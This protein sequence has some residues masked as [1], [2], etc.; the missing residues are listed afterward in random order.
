M[1]QPP[2]ISERPLAVVLGATGCIGGGAAL[3]FLRVGWDVFAPVRNLSRAAHL[4]AAGATVVLV[5][6]GDDDSAG[7]LLEALRPHLSRVRAVLSSLG[8]YTKCAP[9]HASAPGA[10]I[11]LLASNVAPHVNGWRALCGALLGARV[12]ATYFFVT[13]KS[14]ETGRK[15]ALSISDAAVFGV[16]AVARA[17]AAAGASALRVVEVRLMFSVQ[18]VGAREFARLFVDI[19]SGRGPRAHSDVIRLDSKASW[20]DAIGADSAA[21]MPAASLASLA[22]RPFASLYGGEPADALAIAAYARAAGAVTEA[23]F[24]VLPVRALAARPDVRR[25]PLAWHAG[26][27]SAAA[28][29]KL[30]QRGFVSL[31]DGATTLLTLAAPFTLEDDALPVVTTTNRAVETGAS[32]LPSQTAPAAAMVT[33]LSAAVALRV[34]ARTALLDAIALM[35]ATPITDKTPGWALLMSIEHKRAVHETVL[36]LVRDLEV[37]DLAG[38]PRGWRRAL[39]RARGTDAAAAAAAPTNALT[40]IVLRAPLRGFALP[41]T[42]DVAAPR[43]VDDADVA[44]RLASRADALRACARAGSADRLVPPFDVSIYKVSNAEFLPFVVSGGYSDSRW[45]GGVAP[46]A[47][48]APRYWGRADGHWTL[49]ETWE[50]TP[51]PWDWPVEVDFSEA[52]AFLAWLT[53]RDGGGRVLHR[54]PT[55]AEHR[56][57]W[58]VEEA[59]AAH[60][61]GFS[62]E[63]CDPPAPLDRFNTDLRWHS[64]CAVDE[65]APTAAG[66]YDACGNVWEWVVDGNGGALT[67]GSWVTSGDPATSTRYE[68]DTRVARG[69]ANGAHTAA[70]F[71]YVVEGRR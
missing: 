69:D 63:L 53:A 70:S 48:A 16:A 18:L 44:E 27:A 45:W 55:L 35:D 30:V 38:T 65:V 8:G 62:G 47:R 24:D 54:L 26:A 42:P 9:L 23:L 60:A 40:C 6:L 5:D 61:R 20:E 2:S 71:R 14:G 4:S 56:A 7:V 59:D 46:P 58:S 36:A 10:A 19:A 39:S 12:K 50:V 64:P 66:V 33:D 21:A 68:A 15:G 41:F 22:G 13:G 52:R 1:P 32:A 49:R 34:R 31:D 51:M 11:A 67:G 17:E 37:T 25:R 57:L 43:V 3:E 28:V 29:S